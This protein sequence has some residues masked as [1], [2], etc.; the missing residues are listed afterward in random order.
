MMKKIL[1]IED[2]PDICKQLKWGLAKDY[3]LL[4]AHDVAGALSLV[5]KQMPKVVTLDLGLPPHEDDSTEGIRCLEELIKQFPFLKV[6]VITGNN[7]RESALRAIELGAYDY[8]EKPIDLNE[9]KVILKRAFHVHAL[10]E[11]NL[12]LHDQL[13]QR[14]SG[15]SNIIGQCDAMERVFDTVRKVASS[16]VPVLIQ[17]ESGTGKELVAL[18]IHSLSL[19]NKGPF[20]PLN[21]GAIPEN[22]LESE[23]FGHEKGA[24]TGAQEQIRGK[25]EYADQGT[26]FLDEIGELPANL[27]VKLLRFLQDKNIQRVGGR[28]DIHVDARI[29]AATN[30][31]INQAIH[32]GDFREDLYYRI[33]VISI[34][35]PNLSSRGND[36]ILLSNYFLNKFTNELKKKIRGFSNEALEHLQ[37]YSWPG[38]VR[39]LENRIQ[40]AVIMS[41]SSLIDPHNLG[42]TASTDKR[43]GSISDVVSLK[44][45]RD[46]IERTVITAAIGKYD[47]NIARAAA[48]LKI[49]RPTLYDLMKKHEMHVS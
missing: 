13:G 40:R 19:R 38:N 1:I 35:L 33:S 27:Q 16:D 47:G 17:G 45:A 42:L 14:T 18:A 44:E 20:I 26:L 9:L 30:R 34:N 10:E 49:S 37:S 25:V 6:V 24:F 3:K 2:N 31:D 41:E 29:I 46:N 36:I 12:T 28:D 7:E 22:L 8:Y 11:E 23:L 5:K 48:A 32:E 39:E 15:M 21:C 4:F 43:N